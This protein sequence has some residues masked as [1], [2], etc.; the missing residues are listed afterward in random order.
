MV[1]SAFQPQ[2]ASTRNTAAVCFR[3]ALND[4]Q[5]MIRAEFDLVNVKIELFYLTH[6]FFDGIDADGVTG[7]DEVVGMQPPDPV[8]GQAFGLAEEVVGGII[9][10]TMQERQIIELWL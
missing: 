2:L 7:F 6:H 10:S 5:V 9:E 8:T 3:S 4:L 1:C